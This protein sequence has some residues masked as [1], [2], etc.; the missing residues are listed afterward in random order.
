LLS[1]LEFRAN[2]TMHRPVLDALEL[3]GTYA[4]GNRRYYPLDEPVSVHRGA[5]GD[6]AELVYQTDKRGHRRVVRMVYETGTFQALRDR[7]RVQGD[8]GGGCREVAQP[9]AGLTPLSWSHVLPYGEVKL[10]MNTH[11]AL[12]GPLS[13]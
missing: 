11:L 13:V 7:L 1:V 3:I 10:D 12:S 8:L 4:G 2:N 9:G 6:G 5:S